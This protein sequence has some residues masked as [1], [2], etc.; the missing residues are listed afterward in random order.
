MACYLVFLS[1]LSFFLI[2]AKLTIPIAFCY[3]NDFLKEVRVMSK[4]INRNIVRLLAVC[5]EEE[6]FAMV[7][8]YMEHGDLNQYLQDFDDEMKAVPGKRIIK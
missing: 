4:L 3:R 2:L 1:F 8:E 7:T 5:T 6:P